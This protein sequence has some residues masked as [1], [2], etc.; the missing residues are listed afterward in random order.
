MQLWTIVS[1]QLCV[2]DI[3]FPVTCVYTSFLNLNLAGVIVGGVVGSVAIL[4]SV[5]T[6]LVIVIV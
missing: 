3:L 2:H 1:I 4:A 5:A 6:V